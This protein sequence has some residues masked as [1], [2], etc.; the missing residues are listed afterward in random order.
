MEWVVNTSPRLLYPPGRD[1]ILIARKAGWA[2]GPVW[3]GEKNNPTGIRSPYRPTR[4]EL[5]PRLRYLVLLRIASNN[6]LVMNNEWKGC[7]AVVVVASFKLLCRYSYV[8]SIPNPGYACPQ[9]YEPE[10]LRVREKN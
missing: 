4:I 3:T 2:S 5:P 9:G 7:G 6:L 1:P 10:L 8:A